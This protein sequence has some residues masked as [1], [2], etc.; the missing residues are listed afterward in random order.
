MLRDYSAD[1]QKELVL[2]LNEQANQSDDEDKVR[3]SSIRFWYAGSNDRE[4]MLSRKQG[5]Y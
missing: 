2:L 5:R 3:I 1:V 4:I